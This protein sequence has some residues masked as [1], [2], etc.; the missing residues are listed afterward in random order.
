M[1]HTETT[2]LLD[3]DINDLKRNSAN[4]KHSSCKKIS[5]AFAILVAIL[6]IVYG[7]TN[8]MGE[9]TDIG[10][11]QFSGVP[12][13]VMNFGLQSQPMYDSIPTGGG[14]CRSCNGST[15][16]FI[17]GWSPN[18]S[19]TPSKNSFSKIGCSAVSCK[20]RIRSEYDATRLNANNVR[21][22][23]VAI[24]P[25]FEYDR[26]TTAGQRNLL[27]CNAAEVMLQDY[28]YCQAAWTQG[29]IPLGATSDGS[30][31]WFNIELEF[32][33]DIVEAGAFGLLDNN[34]QITT[35]NDL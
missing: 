3:K 9:V 24:D 4:T 18:P 23:C 35:L 33:R 34:I 6:A 26:V 14:P 30:S 22:F 20:S 8:R 5:V 19:N 12:S 31:E 13:C 17:Y 1:E 21:L 11:V 32:A 15:G 28:L 16:G 29:E 2:K 10:N 27:S 7:S 25:N